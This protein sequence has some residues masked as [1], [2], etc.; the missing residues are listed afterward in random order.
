MTLRLVVVCYGTQQGSESESRN[1][2]SDMNP[3][4]A[5]KVEVAHALCLEPGP[6]HAVTLP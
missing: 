3:D 2:V 6:S 4:F 5:I 1:D